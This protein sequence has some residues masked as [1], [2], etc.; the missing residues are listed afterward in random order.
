MDLEIDIESE[1]LA[2]GGLKNI[3]KFIGKNG[4]QLAF[5]VSIITMILSR[6]P[7][8]NPELTKLQIESL[9]LDIELKK[10]ELKKAAKEIAES[11]TIT[12]QQIDTAIS[13]LDKDYKVLWHKSNFYKRTNLYQK[14]DSISTLKLDENNTPTEQEKIIYKGDFHKFILRS[15]E[16]QPFIDDNAV[17]ELISPV[18]KKGNFK[19]KGFY[20]GEA[21][22]FYMKDEIFKESVLNKEVEFANG[23]AIRCVLQQERK[24]DDVGLIKVTKN[25]VL[26]VI[27]IIT[28]TE[29]VSTEQGKRYTRTKQAIKNQL[30]LGLNTD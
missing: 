26:T 10:Q 7:V 6:I 12:Q 5:I 3:W 19:W 24:L 14:V 25:N 17:I 9:K 4:V 18:L 13:V 30:D 1:A 28:S 15:N 29:T 22:S 23:F 11:D 27:E 20:K 2:E 21:I 16:L 8:E